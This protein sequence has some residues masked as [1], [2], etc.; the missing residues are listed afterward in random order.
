MNE[1]GTQLNSLILAKTQQLLAN[2]I[3]QYYAD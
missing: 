2:H 1:S 3:E